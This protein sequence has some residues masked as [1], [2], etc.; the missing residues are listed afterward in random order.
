MADFSALMGVLREVQFD[1]Q[2]R[3][4]DATVTRPFPD[5]TPI[6]T[7]VIWLAPITGGVPT[8]LEFQRRD[9]RRVLAV[10]RDE[11]ETVPRGTFIE[12]PEHPGQDDQRWRVDAIDA[13]F[14]DHVR[15]VVVPD[16]E[17]E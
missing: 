6:E 8:G 16:P 10:R 15:V 9:V 14:P 5:D 4:V 3:A 2:P 1:L 11:V 12:A 13:E 7:R 17:H